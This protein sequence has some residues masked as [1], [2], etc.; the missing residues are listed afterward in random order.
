[1]SELQDAL[2][3]LAAA[4]F[5]AA[6]AAKWWLAPARLARVGMAVV[7]ELSPLTI[8]TVG[9]L[10]LLGA[11]GLLA[12]MLFGMPDG[13]ARLAAAGLTV[14]MVGASWLQVTKRRSLGAA[15][16]LA[17]LALV[18][19]LAVTPDMSQGIL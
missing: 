19:T 6:G 9:T 17:M 4:A 10:E 5:L 1:M 8:R 14:L 16:A 12:P 11:L 3:I 13:V 2:R 15:I 18:T 7:A